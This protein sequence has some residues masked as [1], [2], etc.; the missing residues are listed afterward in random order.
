[1]VLMQ[2]SFSM[3]HCFSGDS[4]G[5]GL[6]EGI[7]LEQG[8]GE[9]MRLEQGFVA[10]FS[11]LLVSLQWKSLQD[12]SKLIIFRTKNCKKKKIFANSWS[13]LGL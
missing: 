9:G 7:C 4:S 8:V 12:Y 1:M 13:S 5:A 11:F 10:Y 3:G 6:N 2:H